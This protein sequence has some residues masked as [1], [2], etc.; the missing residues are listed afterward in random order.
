MRSFR[1]I[2]PVAALCSLFLVQSSL[3]LA[4]LAAGAKTSARP[5][6]TNP[7]LRQCQITF[8]P[9]IV[10]ASSVSTYALTNFKLSVQ[11]DPALVTV[12]DV[13]FLLPYV[14]NTPLIPGATPAAQPGAASAFFTNDN[15]NGIIGNIS[16]SALPTSVPP[17]QDVDIFYVDFILNRGVPTTTP[18]PFTIFANPATSDF[19]QGTDPTTGAKVTTPPTGV[20]EPTTIDFSFDQSTAIANGT[21]LPGGAAAGM[22]TIGLL[23]GAAYLRRRSLQIA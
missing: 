6:A 17:G 22:I 20:V 18:L 7:Q 14:E 23:G 10:D 15:K 8:D 21:P 16:A 11:Y 19:T 12:Q 13:V 4:Q 9:A 2:A 1:A 5:T 3:G